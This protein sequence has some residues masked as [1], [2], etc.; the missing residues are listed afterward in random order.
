MMGRESTVKKILCFILT[1]VITV[2]CFANGV[3]AY[4]RS[5][6]TENGVQVEMAPFLYKSTLYQMEFPSRLS[7]NIKEKSVPGDYAVS[8]EL[9]DLAYAFTFPAGTTKFECKISLDGKNGWQGVSLND[10][11]NPSYWPKDENGN[12]DYSQPVTFRRVETYA[13]QDEYGILYRDYLKDNYVGGFRDYDK[14]YW[15]LTYIRNGKEYNEYFEIKLYD[16]DKSE[17]HTVKA[18]NFNVAGLPFS[19]LSG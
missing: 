19:A 5:F 2:G 9:N 7:Y 1:V 16:Y 4:T 10:S 18:V 8:R 6:E 17:K 12:I 3:V 15:R 14:I 13:E 11:E